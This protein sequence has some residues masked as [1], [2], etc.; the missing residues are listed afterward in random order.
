M[1]EVVL[2]RGAPAVGKSTV[3]R[4]LGEMGAVTAIIEVDVVRR[5]LTRVRWGEPAQHTVA[6]YA[7][8]DAATAFARA[9]PPALLVDALD[10]RYL[11]ELGRRLECAGARAS[12]VGLWARPDVL[13]R[14]ARGREKRTRDPESAAALNRQ[15]EQAAVR[16][17]PIVDTSDLTPG[18]AADAVAQLI[19]RGM[20]P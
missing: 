9:A 15:I 4:R 5:M 8:T 7:A 16:R 12:V 20:D 14:R 18:Q 3:A 10:D 13:L 17:H 19:L 2:L 11:P 1:A 6:L